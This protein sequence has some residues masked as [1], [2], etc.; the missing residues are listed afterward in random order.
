ME[1]V[2]N[3]GS[4]AIEAI[5]EAPVESVTPEVVE[6]EPDDSKEA[7]SLAGEAL[8]QEA[9]PDHQTEPAPQQQIKDLQRE[10][11]VLKSQVE[12]RTGQ[13]MRIAADFDNFRKRTQKEKE[14]LE[15][16][17]RCST[18]VKLLPVVDN[19][20][21]AR[22]QIVPQTDSEMKIHKSYQ[23]VYKDLVERLK[24]IG[25]SAMRAE[26]QQFDPTLHEAMM[27]EPT[28]Q[29]PEG[30]VIEEFER[31]YLMGDRVLRHAR[32]KVAAAPDPVIPSSEDHQGEN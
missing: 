15:Q 13:Y 8:G 22:M 24:A 11:E 14:E 23:G 3:A 31:G 10:I 25:V 32:V 20:E 16:Q 7:A 12:D 30:T 2:S 17:I 6:S 29:Y 18:L 28:E 5:F 9:Q 19:F 27:Q 4:D 1:E 21:R 26:G